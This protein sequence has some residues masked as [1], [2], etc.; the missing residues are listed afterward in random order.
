MAKYH[1]Y[2]V[3]NDCDEIPYFTTNLTKAKN[4]I[5]GDNTVYE[6]L[7][8]WC[9]GIYKYRD[10]EIELSSTDFGHEFKEAWE[11]LN[12]AEWDSRVKKP[13]EIIEFMLN[14]IK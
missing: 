1:G 8:L 2:L 11:K 12:I 14:K 6:W 9:T 7:D 10:S 5:N 4:R 3:C 13:E